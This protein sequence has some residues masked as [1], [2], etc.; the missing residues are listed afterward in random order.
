MKALADFFPIFLF[1]IAYKMYDLY[2]ATAVIIVA[3]LAQ[4]SYAWFR[5]KKVEKMH[6]ITFAMVAVFGGLTLI[7]QDEMFIKW[8]PSVINWLFAIAFIGS[9]FIGKKTFIERMLSANI[10]LPRA[11]WIKLNFSWAAF[12][13]SLGF[14]NL[15]VVYNYDTDTWVNF[16]MFGMMGLT[17]TFVIVQGIFLMKF[18][19]QQETATENEE[20]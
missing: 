16:K 15:Y 3:S 13:A 14:L 19:K 11:I 5:H 8:K 2:V 10:E 1:F 7:L 6:L 12:F 18:I 17:F 20:G 9:Q 4:I